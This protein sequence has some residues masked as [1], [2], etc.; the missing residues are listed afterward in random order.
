MCI[1]ICIYIHV[2]TSITR[3]NKQD[4]RD[5]QC[6]IISDPHPTS[7]VTCA[8][9]WQFFMVAPSRTPSMWKPLRPMGWCEKPAGD[10]LLS[11]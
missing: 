11:G 1:Y 10:V 8:K 4:L 6:D 3:S 5:C 2:Y 9:C 7:C